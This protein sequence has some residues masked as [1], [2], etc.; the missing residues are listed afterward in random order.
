M[1]RLPGKLAIFGAMHTDTL[2]L[3]RLLG[4]PLLG[5]LLRPAR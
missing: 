3:H 1:L 5:L 4:S 2:V